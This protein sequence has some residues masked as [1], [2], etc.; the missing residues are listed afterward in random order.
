MSVALRLPF[1]A[2]R[3]GD[4]WGLLTWASG[5][6]GREFVAVEPDQGGVPVCIRRRLL[7]DS[8]RALRPFRDL[9][10]SVADGALRF[11][12]RGGRGGLDLRCKAS[13]EPGAL[14]P[15]GTI[16]FVAL[17]VEDSGLREAPVLLRAR[18]RAA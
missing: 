6:K 11:R 4:P 17:H 5:Q 3:D 2:G 8:K 14:R 15:D 16:M 13:N 7:I 12:W 9:R 18:R 10:A 1:P